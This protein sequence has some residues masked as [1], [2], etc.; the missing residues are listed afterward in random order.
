MFFIVHFFTTKYYSIRFRL[1]SIMVIKTL[2]I[3]STEPKVNSQLGSRK[4]LLHSQ[5]GL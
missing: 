2:P 5:S 4:P 3:P 1:F